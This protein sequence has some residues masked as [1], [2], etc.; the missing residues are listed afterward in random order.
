MLI[1]DGDIMKIKVS[2]TV[3]LATVLPLPW[4]RSLPRYVV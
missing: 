2:I 1:K 3:N 4:E